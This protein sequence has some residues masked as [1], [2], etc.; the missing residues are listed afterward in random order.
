MNKIRPKTTRARHV[1][2]KLHTYLFDHECQIL[3]LDIIGLFREVQKSRHT[4][5]R[6]IYNHCYGM[7]LWI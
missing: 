2:S 5:E 4:Y 6:I 7:L 3:F 1:E